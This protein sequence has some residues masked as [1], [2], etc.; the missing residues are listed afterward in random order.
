[1]VR[2]RSLGTQRGQGLGGV[3]SHAMLVIGHTVKI[4]RCH[5]LLNSSHWAFARHKGDRGQTA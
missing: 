2:I 5:E 3:N 4:E 1:L